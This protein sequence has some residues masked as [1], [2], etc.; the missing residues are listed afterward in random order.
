MLSAVIQAEG[1]DDLGQ[2]RAWLGGHFLGN[3]TV[4]DVLRQ[5]GL[6]VEHTPAG[7]TIHRAYSLHPE[8]RIAPT[9]ASLSSFVGFLSPSGWK[10]PE[11]RGQ[12]GSPVAHSAS[13]RPGTKRRQHVL[14]SPRR[15]RQNPETRGFH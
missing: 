2:G 5:A 10:L 8:S 4:I 7:Q 14:G 6:E 12:L 1:D 3:N 13:T 9:V 15:Q 11:G